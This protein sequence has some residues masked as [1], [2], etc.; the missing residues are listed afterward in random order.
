[1]ISMR[2]AEAEAPARAAESRGAERNSGTAPPGVIATTLRKTTA[3]P[4]PMDGL[5][6]AYDS[7]ERQVAGVDRRLRGATVG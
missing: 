7:R 3:G 4:K 2:V 5:A 1:M 6:S